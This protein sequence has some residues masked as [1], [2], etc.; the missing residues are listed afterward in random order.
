[1]MTRPHP[2]LLKI[3][4]FFC[5]AALFFLAAGLPGAQK[6]KKAPARSSSAASLFSPDKGK[7]KILV[8][9]QQIGSEDFEISQEGGSWIARGKSDVQGQDGARTHVLSTLKLRPDGIPQS[10]DWSVEGGKKTGAHILFENGVAKITLEMEGSAPFQQEMNFETPRIV[11]LDNNL[12]H[13]YAILARV[14]DWS[15][16]GVQTFPVLIPQDVTPGSI[17]VESIGQRAIDGK[18]YSGLRIA[19]ADLEVFAYLDGDHRLMQ[20]EVPSAKASIVRE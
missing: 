6:N 10:Y 8:G 11:V 7:L 12:F 19:S 1:M 13:Q 4:A 17:Q 20:V 16:G 3:S 14:Y 18:S 15:A 9:G 2:P 5:F